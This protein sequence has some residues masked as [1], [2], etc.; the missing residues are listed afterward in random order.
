M[1]VSNIFNYIIF[2]QLKSPT[3]Q[4]I[5]AIFE[6]D[7]QKEKENLIRSLS[8]RNSRESGGSE[9][10][11]RNSME[12]FGKKFV[13]LTPSDVKIPETH[14]IPVENEQAVVKVSCDVI[15]IHFVITQNIF[16]LINSFKDCNTVFNKIYFMLSQPLE[17]VKDCT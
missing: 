1:C 17:V 4:Q 7:I 16:E 13:D 2:L 10:S 9:G 5:V 8:R 6:A 12:V 11:R 14:K 3:A 15:I